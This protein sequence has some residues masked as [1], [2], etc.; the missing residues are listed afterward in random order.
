MLKAVKK[1]K[2]YEQI[3]SQ[4]KDLITQGKLK[5]GDQLPPERELSE[6]FRVSRAS[7]R[8][9]IRSLE[10]Q[11]L[12]DSR[13]GDGTYIALH[14]VELLVQPLASALFAEKE[15]QIEL[16]EMRRLIE[17]Q[18]AYLAT[19]RA[20]PDEVARMEEILKWQEEQIA[21]GESGMEADTAFHYALAQAAKNRILIR[22]V[23][24]MVDLLS[25]SRD[26]SLQVLGRPSKSLARHKEIL[27]AIKS[28]N[29][30]RAAMAM[31]KHIEAIERNLLRTQA[32]KTQ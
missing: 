9:A 25:Q 1:T 2:I 6:T 32:G 10:S 17:P 11:G 26:R 14:A 23:N 29:K 13:Q 28:G 7:V 8:E 24:T 12:L 5:S 3:V 22:I 31:R 20:T 19:E 15:S 27:E 4:I 30:E 16:F 18:L 21:Q